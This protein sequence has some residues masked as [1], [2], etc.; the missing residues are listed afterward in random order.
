LAY[1]T[2]HAFLVDTSPAAALG[3]AQALFNGSFNLGV[4][5][6]AFLFGVIADAW[7]QRWMFACAACTPWLAALLFGVGAR[8]Q[9]PAVR[10]S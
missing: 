4:M 10:A 6:S 1:P 7:G 5:A 3:K 8:N 9:G 2:L